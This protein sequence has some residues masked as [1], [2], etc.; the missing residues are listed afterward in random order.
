MAS[1]GPG[2]SI[3]SNAVGTLA[4]A[5]EFA[6]FRIQ[7]LAQ[8]FK[9]VRLYFSAESQE[10]R[11]TAHPAANDTLAFRVIVAVFEV[12][13]RISLTVGHGANREHEAIPYGLCYGLGGSAG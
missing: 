3:R 10:F 7:S 11:T 5:K 8:R 6:C 2:C 13:G 12:P 1:V 4:L 9:V